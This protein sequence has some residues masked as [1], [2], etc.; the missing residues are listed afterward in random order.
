MSNTITA[1]FKGRA[2]VAESVYQYDY[3]KILI[4]DGLSLPATFEVHFTTV[5]E[6]DAITVIGQNN[7]VAI[8]DSCINKTGTVTAYIYLHTG[9]NDGETEYVIKFAVI[10]RARPDYDEDNKSD[11]ESAASQALAMLQNP[12]KVNMPLDVFNQVDNG[13]A[14]Q[15]LRTKG[16]GSTEWVDVGLPTDEQ[17][18][19]AVSAWLDEHP[20]ATTTVEDG[21]LTESKLSDA[22][23]LK[24]IKDYVTPD[25]F[26]AKGDGL[27]DD[28]IAIQDAIDYAISTS[29]WL[30]GLNKEYMVSDDVVLPDELTSNDEKGLYING[31]L[32]MKNFRFI[33]KADVS[34]LTTVLNIMNS[35]GDITIVENIQ[36]N[37]N[38]TN[39]S[40]VT[41]PIQ[42]GGLH[43]MRIGISGESAGKVVINNC[44]IQNCYSD[45]IDV[46]PATFDQFII[47]NTIVTSAGRNGITD[48]SYSSLVENCIIMNNGVRANPKSGYHIEPDN[49]ADFGYKQLVN[50]IIKDNV[51]SDFKI[52]FNTNTFNIEKLSVR[53]CTIG[54]FGWANYETSL[55]VVKKIEFINTDITTEFRLTLNNFSVM[56]YF[57][58][59]YFENCRFIDAVL[60][61]DGAADSTNLIPRLKFINCDFINYPCRLYKTFDQV[62]FDNCNF[63][64]DPAASSDN[65]AS[66]AIYVESYG[67]DTHAKVIDYFVVN[68]CRSYGKSRFIEVRTEYVTINR[69]N[70]VNND[71]YNYITIFRTAGV[72]NTLQVLNNLFN[73]YNTL[74][75]AAIQAGTC[76]NMIAT[77]NM[78]TQTETMTFG[79]DDVTNLVKA[80]N[81]FSTS[82]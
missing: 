8:P 52:H 76:I 75:A 36:I 23:K 73:I 18:A 3:G 17:T 79:T 62:I 48:N 37:G 60:D 5:S 47:S 49:S 63:V 40:Q 53:D 41:T 45:G 6:N 10:R 19:A 22:L 42:D 7:R 1:F 50:C 64:S 77:N 71:F 65:Q 74:T 25:M 15:L 32:Y 55:S 82:F 43:G 34:D 78:S 21:S 12:R 51:A 29:A 59:L 56:A 9:D 70:I 44:K 27:T 30:D 2:G 16:N 39:Q 54:E 69:L 66:Y 28:T 35:T 72:V 33:L 61:I 58:E 24:V 68:N 11:W 81:I 13:T 31:T 20:E 38:G 46:R 57:E 67:S 26:G 80:N 4:I 14:G